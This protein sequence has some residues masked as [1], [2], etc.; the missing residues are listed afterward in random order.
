MKSKFQ[1]AALL[2]DFGLDDQYVGTMKGIIVSLAP[3][4]TIVDISH[5]VSPQNINEGAFLLWAAFRYFPRGTIFVAIVDPGVGTSRKI[6][7]AEGEGY[8]FLAP[9]NGLL[10]FVLGEVHASKIIS[11][12]NKRLFLPQ[13]SQTFHGRDIFAPVCAHLANG[14][15]LAKLGKEVD[16]ETRPEYFL[17]FNC[18]KD[19]KLK[20]SIVYTDHFG[21]I[22]TN[23]CLKNL[24][25]KAT[26]LEMK[27]SS[28]KTIRG[29][30]R[31]YERA[32]GKDPFMIIGSTGLLEVSLQNGNAAKRLRARIG[33]SVTLVR[34]RE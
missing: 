6:I 13:V 18:S 19:N 26:S 5:G 28:D 33:D 34:R 1:V 16:P 23:I 15:S 22:V 12:E 27:L 24:S 14:V 17:I 8:I 4:V 29:F 10:K 32:P 11:V 20:G 31:T 9:D 7:C 30:S 21:N 25:L 3:H 2:T